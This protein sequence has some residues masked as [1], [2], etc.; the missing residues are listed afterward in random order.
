WEAVHVASWLHDCGKVTTPEY[1]VDKATKL[2][3]IYDRIH[4]VR[5]RFEVLKRDAEIACLKAVAAGEAE[6]AATARLAA[7]LKQ[8]DDDFAF[9]ATCNEGGEFMAPEKIDRLK[10]IG[11]RTWMRTLDDRIGIAYEERARK[12][13]TPAPALPARESLLADKPE[14]LFERRP[15]DRMPEDN[16]WGFRMSVP[17]LLYN[18]GELYNLSVARGTL[19]EEERYKINEH[20]VQTLIMLGQLPFP[21]HLRGVPEIAGGHHEKM[22]GTGYPKRLT[23]E[24][25]SPVARMM[26]IADIF[27]AL[28]AADRPYKKGKLLS[29]A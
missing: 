19:S 24:Q 2:E 21:Q 26:A 22:D 23:R 17:E 8:L 25:M 27:E 29:E 9:V 20:I 14:H 15:H 1:I 11:Q 10:A 5:I 3:T 13:C 28:T 18:K 6:P 7:G 4:E 16:K 12:A